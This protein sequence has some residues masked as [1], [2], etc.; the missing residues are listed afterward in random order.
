MN[1]TVS[2]FHSEFRPILNK[3][4]E[5]DNDQIEFMKFSL[6]KFVNTVESMGTETQ[7]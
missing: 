2:N 1:L 3:I 5:S 7:I 6:S 4:Q